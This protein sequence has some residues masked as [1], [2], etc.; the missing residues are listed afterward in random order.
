MTMFTPEDLKA[1][2]NLTDNAYH[3]IGRR[4]RQLSEGWDGTMPEFLD[5]EFFRKYFNYAHAAGDVDDLMER[6][7]KVLDIC[8]ST[9]EVAMYAHMYYRAIFV[10]KPGLSSEDLTPPEIL[11]ENGGVFN[12]LVA[13]AAAPLIEKNFKAFGIPEKYAHD[14]IQWLGGAIGIYRQGHN[15]IPGHSNLQTYWL[16]FYADLKLFRIGRL[17]YL[18]HPCPAWAPMVFRAED[19]RLQVLASEGGLFDEKGLVLPA[20]MADKAVDTADVREDGR[21]VVGMPIAEDGHALVGQRVK[22]DT[23]VFKPVCTPWSLVPSMHIP[24]G[25]RLDLEEVKDSLRQ[26]KEFFRTYFHR[27]VPM[28]V[29]ESWILN[30]AWRRYLPDG[31]M[32]RLQL[33]AHAAQPSSTT[34]KDGDFF[35]FGRSDVPVDRLPATNHIQRVLQQA[36]KEEGLLRCGALFVLADEI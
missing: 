17:E 19:G 5:E 4:W 10:V 36:L 25:L 6:I 11:G 14:I 26:A 28:F 8:R 24:G 1:R 22:V 13:M 18:M 31:N 7:R 35:V 30:P 16:R 20:S 29:C 21:F 3:T 27:D 12:L 23:S 15:G 9:P 33:W 34:G 32:T 2:L